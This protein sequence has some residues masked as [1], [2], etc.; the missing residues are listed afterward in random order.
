M[1][2]FVVM[3]PLGLYLLSY[4]FCVFSCVWICASNYMIADET[5][6]FCDLSDSVFADGKA[7]EAE[8]KRLRLADL[9]KNCD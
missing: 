6:F 3:D 2:V 5:A 9:F 1:V 7:D 8:L 4:L